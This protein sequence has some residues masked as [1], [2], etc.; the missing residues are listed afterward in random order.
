MQSE[1][2]TYAEQIQGEQDRA[3]NGPL[4]YTT[5]EEAADEGENSPSRTEPLLLVK[6]DSKRF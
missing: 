3:E 5:G 4:R 6:Y 2:G 1:G